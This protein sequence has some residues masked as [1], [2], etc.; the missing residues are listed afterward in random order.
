MNLNIIF[1]LLIG[2]AILILPLVALYHIDKYLENHLEK[3]FIDSEIKIIIQ[4]KDCAHAI[5]KADNTFTCE[6]MNYKK[7]C[8]YY[9]VI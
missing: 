7:P 9:V 1:L 5:E 6:Y 8:K 4:C 2:L 3:E